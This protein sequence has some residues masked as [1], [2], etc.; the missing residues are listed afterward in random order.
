MRPYPFRTRDQ[1][2]ARVQMLD[3][4]GAWVLLITAGLTIGAMFALFI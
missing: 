1:A 2:R 3:A 4:I